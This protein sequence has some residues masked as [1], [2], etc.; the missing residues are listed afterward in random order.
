MGL[1][2]SQWFKSNTS[3]LSSLKSNFLLLLAIPVSTYQLSSLMP[4]FHNYHGTISPHS[5]FPHFQLNQEIWE[6]RKPV[7][8][9]PLLTL[10]E[11]NYF[12][13]AF[14][15]FLFLLPCNPHFWLNTHPL[16]PMC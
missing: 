5:R 7:E 8:I 9:G 14:F 10:S 16:R 11:L 1:G 12:L 2:L 13:F 3:V 6:T 15:I 4:H